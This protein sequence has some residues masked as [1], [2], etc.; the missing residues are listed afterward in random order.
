MQSGSC[1]RQNEPNRTQ[2]A[3]EMVHAK[4]EKETGENNR[5]GLG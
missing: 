3:E 5:V 2:R 4:K 1:G